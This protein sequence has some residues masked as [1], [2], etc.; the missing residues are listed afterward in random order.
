MKKKKKKEKSFLEKIQK[1]PLEI[2]K[3]ILWSVIII[4]GIMLVWAWTKNFSKRLQDFQIKETKE[5]LKFPDLRKEIEKGLPN[6]EVPEL[7]NEY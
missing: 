4:L 6:L 1:L 3:I 2:R 7:K 5:Q